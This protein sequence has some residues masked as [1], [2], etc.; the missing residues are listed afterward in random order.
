[1]IAS[2]R[3]DETGGVPAD[4]SFRLHDHEEVGPPRPE[5][6]QRSP[7][8]PIK[9]VQRWTGPLALQ[10]GDLLAQGE[11]LERGVPTSAEEDPDRGQGD[12][13]N[14]TTVAWGSFMLA[15]PAGRRRKLLICTVIGF[16]L[17][18]GQPDARLRMPGPAVGAQGCTATSACATL[19]FAWYTSGRYD[20]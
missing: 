17:P 1:M 16:C 8:Q 2:A 11:H 13:T 3:T 18:T 7:E 9:G 14:S 10:H 6:A 12:K 5:T 20:A 15:A 19:F 4:D